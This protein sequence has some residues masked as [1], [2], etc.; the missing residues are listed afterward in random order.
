VARKFRF[1]TSTKLAG[2]PLEVK[3]KLN[4]DATPLEST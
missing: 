2:E 3:V 4:P 1:G